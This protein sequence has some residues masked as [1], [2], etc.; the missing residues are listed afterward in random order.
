MIIHLVGAQHSNYPWGFENRLISAI[1]ELGHTLISTDF[2]QERARLPELLQQKADLILVCKGE[3]I[4]PHLIESCPCI[5]ALWY[6]EQ[7]G[8]ADRWDE[9]ALSRRKEL[10]FNVHAF[11]YVFSHDPANLFVY[12]RLETERVSALPCAA[13]D[14]TL[15]R[16]LNLPK[17]YDII[18]VGSKTERRYN[19]LASLEK[20]GVKIHSAEIWDSEEMN[21]IFNESRI[22]LNLHLSDLLNTETRVAEVLG[23]GTFLLTETLSDPTLVENGTHCISFSSGNTEEAVGKVNYYLN[24]PNERER[25]AQCGYHHIHM[26]HTYEIRIKQIIDTID[27]SLKKRIW[28]SY[29]LGVPVG[30]RNQATLRLDRFNESIKNQIAKS[31]LINKKQLKITGHVAKRSWCR[32]NQETIRYLQSFTDLN[33]NNTRFWEYPFV[34]TK[35]KERPTS[36]IIDIGCGKGT[37]ASVLSTCGYSVV[38]ADNYDSCWKD[39]AEDMARTGLL[40]INSEAGNLKEFSDGEFDIALLISVIEHIPSNTIWC[41]KRQQVKTAA[42]LAG[43]T[44]KKIK[45]ISEALRVTKPGGFLIITSD[46]YLDYPMDMNISWRNL[47]GVEG[48]SINDFYDTSDLYIVD[49]PIHKG[50]VLPLGIV[51]KKQVQLQSNFST[52]DYW[53]ERYNNGGN[54]GKGSYGS[55][56]SFKADIINKFVSE[57]NIKSAIEFGVGDGHNLKLYKIDKFLGIDVSSKAIE[58]CRDQYLK[59]DSRQFAAIK[60]LEEF[61]C[62]SKFDCSLSIDVL[63]HLVEQDVYETHL[64]NLFTSADKFVIIYAW[65][66][67][68]KDGMKLSAHVKPRKFT[69]YIDSKFGDWELIGNVKQ[70]YEE[71]SSDF[72][73][74]EKRSGNLNMSGR[75]HLEFKPLEFRSNS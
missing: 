61:V 63:Y 39:M 47:L 58:I 49:N 42:M 40:F 57:K 71:S 59:D 56:A 67:D 46:L 12:K 73:F 21:K 5:T 13:V 19:L 8:T 45:V 22:I 33:M 7:I 31:S 69:K 64:S 60:P 75:K 37:F 11:D 14:S 32:D 53:N 52:Y 70:I 50:R 23:A 16:K 25:I 35:I 6:A 68:E 17:K 62:D 54:S 43:E 4:E 38:G 2:R 27:F 3:G 72:Y 66:T 26:N 20:K 41:E 51:I 36:K 29:I 15:N 65:D 74:Y 48:L 10:A 34:F 30:E 1:E 24:H 44:P 18:F 55:L 9:T 28:P